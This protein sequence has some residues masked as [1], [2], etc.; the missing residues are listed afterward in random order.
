MAVG[1]MLRGISGDTIWDKADEFE[2]T[3]VFDVGVVV[4]RR[5]RG[6]VVVVGCW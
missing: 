6:A 4:R 2:A 5:G 3:E 1:R